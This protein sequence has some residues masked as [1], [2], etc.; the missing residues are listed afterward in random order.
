[1]AEEYFPQEYP[2][3]MFHPDGRLLPGTVQT[4]DEEAEYKT[5]GFVNSPAEYGYETCPAASAI[6]GGG[7]VQQGYVAPAAPLPPPSPAEPVPPEAEAAVA[8][9]EGEVQEAERSGPSR[10]RY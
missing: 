5:Q 4:A 8:K 1:M 3:W 2:K 9:L 10:R 6:Q 7:F